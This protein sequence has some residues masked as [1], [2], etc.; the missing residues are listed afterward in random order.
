[1]VVVPSPKIFKNFLRTYKK[2]LCKV[3]TYRFSGYRDPTI[4]TDRQT[5]RQT[6]ILLLYYKVIILGEKTRKR[7]RRRKR[8]SPRRTRI[9]REASHL[10]TRI[11][12]SS[13]VHN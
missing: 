10:H 7:P 5:K 6:D 8:R 3:E 9:N 2:L 13:S 12:G 1:M 11:N 4:H